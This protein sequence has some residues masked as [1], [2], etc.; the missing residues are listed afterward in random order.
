MMNWAPHLRVVLE[1]SPP[2]SKGTAVLILFAV[3]VPSLLFF[4][5]SLSVCRALAPSQLAVGV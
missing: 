4:L 1:T 3:G 2:I 5:A